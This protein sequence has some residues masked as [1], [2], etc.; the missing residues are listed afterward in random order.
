MIQVVVKPGTLQRDYVVRGTENTPVRSTPLANVLSTEE[1]WLISL[2]VPGLSREA[3]QI[4]IEKSTLRIEGT[5]PA[6]TEGE[7]GILRREFGQGI[8]SRS[9]ILPETAETG[10]IQAKC[11]AGI[12]EIRIPKKAAVQI[13]VL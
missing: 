6:N 11:E 13:P 5:Y 10:S 8:L 7:K 2:A 12:L 4:N 3:V 9:F 1:G